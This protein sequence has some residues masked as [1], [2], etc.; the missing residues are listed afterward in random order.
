MTLQTG[1]KPAQNGVL[2]IGA[3][4]AGLTLA[5]SMAKAGVKTTIVEKQATIQPS[6]WAILL[7][8]VAMKLFDELGVLEDI[9]KL[10]MSLKGP[11]VDTSD[12]KVLATFDAGL[13]SEP[14]LNYWLL[15]GPSEIRKILRERVISEGVELLEG[16]KS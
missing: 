3:G 10:G 12:G 13:I 7:Y 5:L 9:S 4:L 14:R 6:E 8:P 15:A 2:I 11:E 1:P 16:V